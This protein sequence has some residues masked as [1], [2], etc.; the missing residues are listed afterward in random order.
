MTRILKKPEIRKQEIVDTA[1][2][3]FNEKGYD[4]TSIADIA[5]A[6]GIVPSLC[7][8][9]FSSKQEIFEIAVKEYAKESSKDFIKII[10]DRTKSFKERLD[11]FGLTMIN[12]E[13]NSKYH[14]FFHTKGNETFHLQLSIEMFKYLSPF[15]CKELNELNKTTEIQVEDT[16]LVTNFILYGQLSLWLTPQYN[17]RNKPVEEELKQIRGYIYK[18]LNVKE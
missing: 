16:E 9:Y 12:K 15:I 1:M 8:R 6:M 14:D 5:K 7:Y 3:I 4:A 18:L 17:I 10:Q 2:I 11:I 13:E